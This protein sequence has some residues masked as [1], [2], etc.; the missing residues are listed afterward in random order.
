MKLLLQLGLV[1]ASGKGGESTIDGEMTR[2]E[3]NTTSVCMSLI[4][5]GK[6]KIFASHRI[7]V[8][9]PLPRSLML[10]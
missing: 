7:V 4:Q 3:I 1:Y 10:H 2:I 9:I 6:I 5:I 8:C